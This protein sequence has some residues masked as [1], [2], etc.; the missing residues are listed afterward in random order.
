MKERILKSQ[1]LKYL[2][3]CDLCRLPQPVE[4]MERSKAKARLRLQI[5][6]CYGERHG[7]LHLMLLSLKMQPLPKA[8]GHGSSPQACSNHLRM[9]YAARAH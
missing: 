3:Q 1:N 2:Q 5:M 7:V 4:V 9:V 8:F 6:K